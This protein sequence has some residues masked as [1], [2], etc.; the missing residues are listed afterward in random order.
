M[1]SLPDDVRAKTFEEHRGAFEHNMI[2]FLQTEVEL[3]NTFINIAKTDE[4]EKA[5]R[6][7]SH[8]RKAYDTVLYF[9]GKIRLSEDEKRHFAGNLEALKSELEKLG[10][11]FPSET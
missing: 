6:R 2:A 1:Q 5:G 9:L 4:E 10:E 7:R 8:A 3:A 11:T